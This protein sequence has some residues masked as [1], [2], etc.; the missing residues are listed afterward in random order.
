MVA[1][2][3]PKSGYV[4]ELPPNEKH[5]KGRRKRGSTQDRQNDIRNCSQVAAGTGLEQRCQGRQQGDWARSFL[6][7][8]AVW[9]F[10][11]QWV[12]NEALVPLWL[13]GAGQTGVAWLPVC[14]LHPCPYRLT[15]AQIPVNTNYESLSSGQSV[16]SDR[17]MLQT[18]TGG[19]LSLRY[20]A[21]SRSQSGQSECPHVPR[22][23]RR[24]LRSP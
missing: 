10:C 2:P 7:V 13:P 23:P 22:G 24:V 1:E 15:F 12:D 18:A 19:C 3:F 16:G 4:G 21:P 14:L 11:C 8:Q 5:N 6:E 9:E 17:F 20:P